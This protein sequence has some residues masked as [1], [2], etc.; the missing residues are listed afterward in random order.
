MSDD[1]W[2]PPRLEAGPRGG[3]LNRGGRKPNAAQVVSRTFEMFA[4][5]TLGDPEVQRAIRKRLLDEL[6]GKVKNPLPALAVLAA[7]T[8]KQRPDPLSARAVV[9]VAEI[10]GGRG[11][12]TRV[13]L[14]TEEEPLA[15]P[16]A[17]VEATS[18]DAAEA[19][20]VRSE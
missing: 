11:N 5:A 8:V 7:A 14:G 13:E 18:V 4:K 6:A 17:T 19:A 2:K 16:A 3:K 1:D 20:E 10:T 9:F 12:V 15:L